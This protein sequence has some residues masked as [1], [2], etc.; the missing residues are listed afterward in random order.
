MACVNVHRLF[1]VGGV[2]AIKC[3]ASVHRVHYFG[4]FGLCA[5]TFVL[6]LLLFLVCATTDCI[7]TDAAAIPAIPAILA[8][9]EVS[10]VVSAPC[11]SSA[12]GPAKAAGLPS[13]EDLYAKLVSGSIVFSKPKQK[14]DGSGWTIYPQ[15]S[16]VAG[17]PSPQFLFPRTKTPFKPSYGKFKTEINAYTCMNLELSIEDT[18]F[19]HFVVK[20]F[21]ELDKCVRT[22]VALHSKE[23]FKKQLTDGE[24]EFFH[25][26]S[27]VPSA[28]TGSFP[29]LLRV[30]VHPT[31]V[32]T[33]KYFTVTGVNEKKQNTL[34]VSTVDD[35]EPFCEVMNSAEFGNVFVAPKMYGSI[36]PVR[37]CV[38][39]RPVKRGRNIEAENDMTADD[40]GDFATPDAEPVAAPVADTVAAA[41]SAAAREV[42]GD[43]HTNK[44]PRQAA[45]A[46]ADTLAQDDGGGG[47]GGGGGSEED[48]AC[49]TYV[50]SEEE[51]DDD[52]E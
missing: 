31:D 5:G 45:A 21:Q 26:K 20:V 43:A 14:K 37:K 35:M 40:M 15:D 47:G 46:A 8:V 2:V 22:V 38:Q 33:T 1:V 10:N 4:W 42:D 29:Y 11:S 6:V 12:A 13:L 34:R 16:T 17:S 30:K 39:W 28:K 36:F 9:P 24:L 27:I 7:M 25:R 41:V 3:F 19:G 32:K 44:R 23:L 18:P 52:D 50:N 51:D 49:D 48:G